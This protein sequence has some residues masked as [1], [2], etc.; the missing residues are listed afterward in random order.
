MHRQE[1]ASMKLGSGLFLTLFA[2]LV[3][4]GPSVASAEGEMSAECVAFRAD[5][6]AN[7]GD[8]M[9]AGCEPTTGQ[10]SKLMDNPVGNVAMWINQVDLISLTNDDFDKD[11]SEYESIYLVSR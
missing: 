5:M 1:N 2:C 11:R 6:D 7:I 4:W 8:I 9:R 10:M 3:A